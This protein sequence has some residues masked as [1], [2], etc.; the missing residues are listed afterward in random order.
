MK[1]HILFKCKVCG[2]DFSIS[3]IDLSHA[4]REHKYISCPL[5]GK[6]HRINVVGKEEVRNLMEEGKAVKL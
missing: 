4:K 6:H 2:C 5:H 3:K 1:Q